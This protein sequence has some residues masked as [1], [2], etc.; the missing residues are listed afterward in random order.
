ML[1]K[2]YGMRALFTIVVFSI[3]CPGMAQLTDSNRAVLQL[4]EEKMVEMADTMV[5][6]ALEKP[7]ITN[8]YLMITMVKNALQIPGSWYYPFDSLR[9]V[10]ITY[11]PDSSFRT[12]TWGVQM[13]NKRYRHFGA[14]QF[15]HAEKLLLTPLIDGSDFMEHNR[16]DTI[17][18]N[19]HWYGAIYYNIIQ[20]DMD[21]TR[22]YFLFGLDQHDPFSNR[23]L[24]E[25]MHFAGERQPVFGAP[26]FEFTVD[27]TGL[28]YQQQRF[29]MEY[30]AL[31][32]AGLNYDS[33]LEKIIYDHLVPA[34][35]KSRGVKST[36][37]P[38]GTYE[39]FEW[40]GDRWCH[41]DKVFHYDI[42]HPDNPPMPEPIDF[43]LQRKAQEK[44]IKRLEKDKGS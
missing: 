42:G 15:P 12:F 24:V 32:G 40:E 26:V 22:Y 25:V 14:I 10:A 8:A 43:E 4:Y 23:K 33:E 3:T 5:N 17:V 20:R 31:G 1:Y 7:R 6:Y 36:Y 39:G 18:D 27:T 21:S 38:D 16:E 28:P 34:N 44:E 11:P 30:G 13:G 35:P 9:G 37:I 2:S 41:V 19:N 29:F